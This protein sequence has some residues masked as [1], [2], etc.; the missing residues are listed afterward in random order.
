[1]HLLL[2]KETSLLSLI[3]FRRNVDF[4]LA[5]FQLEQQI[6]LQKYCLAKVNQMSGTSTSYRVKRQLCYVLVE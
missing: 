3:G 1:M 2:S 4:P 6:H 5:L